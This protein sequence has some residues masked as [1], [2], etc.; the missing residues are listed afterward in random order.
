MHLF[1]ALVGNLFRLP[2]LRTA[3]RLLGAAVGAV[4]GAITAAALSLAVYGLCA[5]S[6]VEDVLTPTVYE[7]TVLV[8]PLVEAIISY[9]K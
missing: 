7:Q 1:T 8:R 5:V 3:D 4:N 9:L 2:I 6:F